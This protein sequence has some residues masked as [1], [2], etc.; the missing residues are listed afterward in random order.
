MGLRLECKSC[1]YIFLC[2]YQTVIVFEVFSWSFDRNFPDHFY[3]T[4]QPPEVETK[5][6]IKWITSNPFVLSANLHGGSVVANYPLDDYP[7][8]SKDSRTSDDDVFKSL[9]LTY[10]MNHKTMHLG[11]PCPNYPHE[12]FNLGE[13]FSSSTIYKI[14]I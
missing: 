11:K 5:L 12:K 14:T 10:S 9:A 13:F 2:L 4:K 7:P 8:N 3:G 1:R 6:L